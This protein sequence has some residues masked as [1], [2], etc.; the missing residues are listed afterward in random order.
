M[1]PIGSNSSDPLVKRSAEA[2]EP[3]I[4]VTKV[5][6]KLVEDEDVSFKSFKIIELLGQGTFGKV[7]KV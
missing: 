1:S 7:F 4:T 2:T 5:K 3:K 6:E